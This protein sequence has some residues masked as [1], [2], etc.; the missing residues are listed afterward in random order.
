[1]YLSIILLDSINIAFLVCL[2]KSIYFFLTKSDR[3]KFGLKSF[4]NII[5]P[6]GN[7]DLA[8]GLIGEGRMA[9]PE[10]IVYFL[11]NY[12]LKKNDLKG[13]KVL[14]SAG[15]T[16]EPLDP[17]RFIG[18]NSTGKMGI[19]LAK[20]CLIRGAEVTIVLGPTNETVPANAFVIKVITASEMYTQCVQKFENCDIAFM[21]AAVADYTPVLV[22]KDKIKKKEDT[23]TLDLKKTEDILKKLGTLKKAKQILVGFALETNN[24]FSNAQKKLVEKSADFIILNSLND[25]GAGFGHNTNKITIFDKQGEYLSFTLKSKEAVAEDIINTILKK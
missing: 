25:Q 5:L 21:C 17:V 23:F 11:E 14:I 1:M 18:N 8:S 15:P 7:G 22:V 6:V 13:K 19:A 12:F 16:H 2:I 20:E 4:G 9:E 3:L 10:N 24:E